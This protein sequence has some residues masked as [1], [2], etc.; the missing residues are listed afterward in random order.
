[1]S[2]SPLKSVKGSHLGPGNYN[3]E[4]CDNYVKSRTP[5]GGFLK[6]KKEITSPGNNSSFGR[7]SYCGQGRA[8]YTMADMRCDI[9]N[10][11][12]GPGKYDDSKM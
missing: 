1:M 9:S 12:P 11:T 2:A 6:S 3:I 8:S 7:N 5:G 4:A 10:E